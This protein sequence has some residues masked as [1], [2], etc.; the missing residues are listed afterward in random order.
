MSLSSQ[1]FT[2]PR[3]SDMSYWGEAP[4]AHACTHTH[5]H[6]HISLSLSTSACCSCFTAGNSPLHQP[7]RRLGGSQSHSE[8]CVE[9]KNFVPAEDQST[10]HWL[11][12]LQ[13]SHYTEGVSGYNGIHW[14]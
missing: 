2:Q 11:S 5:T 7:N 6:T 10:I 9:N 12:S 1:K 8:F 3:S 14:S 4:H 13:P